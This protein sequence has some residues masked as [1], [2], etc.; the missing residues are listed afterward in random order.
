MPMKDWKNAIVTHHTYQDGQTNTKDS[1]IPRYN[2]ANSHS[3]YT[4]S[5]FNAADDIS[6]ISFRHEH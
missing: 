6:D 4:D 3:V 1:R 2:R 5:M